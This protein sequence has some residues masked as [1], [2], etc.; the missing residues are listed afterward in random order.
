M[1]PC[2]CWSFL[3]PLL[4]IL[5]SGVM[6]PFIRW[7]PVLFSRQVTSITSEI[8]D[9][10][11]PPSNIA[12]P[13]HRRGN[14]RGSRTWKRQRQMRRNALKKT[15]TGQVRILSRRMEWAVGADVTRTLLMWKASRA[16]VLQNGSRL[17]EA[18]LLHNSRFS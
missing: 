16:A 6:R 10:A 1:L 15:S 3:F 8:S 17:L 14:C 4:T 7:L 12:Q 13:M 2:L 5:F 11:I 18:G 9:T